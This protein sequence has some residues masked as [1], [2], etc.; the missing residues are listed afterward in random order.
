MKTMK[1]HYLAVRPTF[2]GSENTREGAVCG[3]P[4]ASYF[5]KRSI[6]EVTC[7]NC[8]KYIDSF[9]ITKVNP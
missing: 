3:N 8:L 1:I 6:N 4:L 7:R 2:S 5:A 9:R